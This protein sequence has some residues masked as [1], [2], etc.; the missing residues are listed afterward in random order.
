MED[1]RRG[2]IVRWTYLDPCLDRERSSEIQGRGASRS[3]VPGGSDFE[4]AIRSAS[5]RTNELHRREASEAR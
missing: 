3:Q 5:D 1:V 4:A 2:V